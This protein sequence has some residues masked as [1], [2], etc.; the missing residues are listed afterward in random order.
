MNTIKDEI[1]AIETKE[2]IGTLIRSREC[3]YKEDIKNIEIFKI[4]EEK[5]G[6]KKEIKSLLDK[7]NKA[8][9][10][11]NS[12]LQIILDFY[13]ELYTSDGFNDQEVDEY[14]GKIEL[15]ELKDE[16]WSVLINKNKTEI[17]NICNAPEE[18]TCLKL[19]TKASVKTLGI[20]FGKASQS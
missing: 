17:L 2:K 12:I 8:T 20:W 4:A 18:D 14:L 15:N 9:D 6:T 16:D 10:D 5:R 7:N 13:S 3:F 11:K 1:I 19:L